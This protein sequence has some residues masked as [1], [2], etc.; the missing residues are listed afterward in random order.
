MSLARK[1]ALAA[2]KSAEEDSTD[3]WMFPYSNL[4]LILVILF[5]AF[6]SF[7]YSE[8]V[9]YETALAELENTKTGG[10]PSP[11]MQEVKLAKTAK[12]TVENLKMSDTVDVTIT[13]RQIKIKLNSPALFESGSAELG[14][15]IRPL[16]DEILKELKGMDNQIIVEGHTDNVPMHSS[17]F[18][19]NWEL[20]AARAFS[21]VRYFIDEGIRPERLA[22]HGLGEHRPIFPNDSE[23]NRAKNR[24][25]EITIMR[26][27]AAKQ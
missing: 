24:R 5:V 7:S 25:I 3:L 6:Y 2:K 26:G 27:G 13:A 16:F 17:D 12:T 22:G 19:S 14:Q 9:E 8:S 20:S 23:E 11:S 21:V 4:M 15:G 10:A 18:N 1:I